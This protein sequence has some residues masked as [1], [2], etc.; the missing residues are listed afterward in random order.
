MIAAHPAF[1]QD[2]YHPD[3]NAHSGYGLLAANL[4]AGAYHVADQGVPVGPSPADI[5]GYVLHLPDAFYRL[6]AAAGPYHVEIDTMGQ[7]GY[8]ATGL[9]RIHKRGAP[10]E[11]SLNMSIVANPRYLMPLAKAK[12]SVALG[13]GWPQ[14]GDWRY[15][16]AANRTTHG[17]AVEVHRE[18]GA[19]EFTVTY[20]GKDDGLGGAAVVHERYHLSDQ[21]LRCAV[22]VP[23]APRL[24][25]Q[26][27]VIE[28]DGRSR[29][30]IT[31]SAGRVEVRYMGHVYLVHVHDSSAAVMEDW[32]AP[33]R[34]G[35]YRVAVFD[36]PGPRISYEATLD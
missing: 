2:G 27:P 22:Q 35:I 4:F 31:L 11:T 19:V 25:L 24:R 10:I 21:G 3:Q 5:G 12:R 29:S 28:T 17:V 9:G 30:E 8:D 15:L 13:V 14:E 36:L 6:W 20:T 1:G 23:G 18:D 34:N 16:A 26:V 32:T 33:N 7:P